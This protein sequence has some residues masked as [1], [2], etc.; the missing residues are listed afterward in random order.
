[1]LIECFIAEISFDLEFICIASIES[2]LPLPLV[3]AILYLRQP[4][5]LYINQTFYPLW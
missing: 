4:E 1:M 3:R 2:Q 5:E